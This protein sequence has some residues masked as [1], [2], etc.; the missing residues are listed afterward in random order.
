V[1]FA[2]AALRD[3]V[4]VLAHLFVAPEAQ[5][6]GVGRGLLAPA[7]AYGAPAKAGIIASTPDPRAIVA[8]AGLPGFEV[9]PAVTAAGHLRRAT[10]PTV[11]H[12]REGTTDDLALATDIDRKLRGGPHGPDLG[13]FLEQ[14]D[15]LL[16]VPDRGYA[17]AGESGPTVVAAL[18]E[19]AAT[20]LLSDCLGQATAE[21]VTI[22][23]MAGGHQWAISVAVGAGL[24][25]RPWGPIVSR[26]C[27]APRSA[28]LQDSALC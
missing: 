17:V 23:R 7:F 9:H 16:V 24:A 20:Q 28:Y 1:G 26:N 8:Y 6:R 21:E 4:W 18:D 3:D 19:E 13:F 11:S 12:V 27:A 2:Q 10:L 5:S 14:G 25:I 22:K 15:R